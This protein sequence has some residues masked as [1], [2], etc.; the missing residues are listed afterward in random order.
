MWERKGLMLSI[1]GLQQ[2]LKQELKELEAG[3]ETE[4]LGYCLVS[5]MLLG[6]LSYKTQS[7]CLKMAPPVV[8]WTLLYL[9]PV[10]KMPDK[11]GHRTA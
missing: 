2:E 5:S 4:I 1:I 10:K 6:Y 7:H 3:T 9:L 11:H 8:G